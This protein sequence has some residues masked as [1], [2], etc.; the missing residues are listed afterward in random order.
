MPD[1][2]DDTVVGQDAN[3]VR[4]HP[5]LSYFLLAYSISWFGALAVA[6]PHLLI[7][8]PIPKLS[9]ILM[10]PVMLLGPSIAGLV[11]ARVVDG[12]E[13]LKGMLC[14]GR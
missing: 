5:I 11:L 3:T 13:G 4:R 1:M 10:F 14:Q 2:S 6:A 7:H 12:R 8:E 9:G